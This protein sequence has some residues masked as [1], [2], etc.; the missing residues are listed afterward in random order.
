[1]NMY[2]TVKKIN[3]KFYPLFLSIFDKYI[4]TTDNLT[5]AILY[6]TQNPLSAWRGG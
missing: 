4:G 2:I 5:P 1:M 3:I 6:Q